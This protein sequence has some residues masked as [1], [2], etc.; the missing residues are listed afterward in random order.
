MNAVVLTSYGPPEALQIRD[1]APPLPKPGQ[2]RIQ[3]RATTVTAGDAELRRS[4]LPWLFRLPLRLWMGW[5]RPRASHA[6]LGMEAAGVIDAI[7]EGV[8][9][10]A[11]G[12]AVF[13]MTDL[14]FG[15]YAEQV[16]V[17]A[18]GVIAHKPT[19][20]SFEQVAP[21]PTG[22][23][24]ALG[25][26]RLGGIAPGKRVL[27]RGALGSIG[28]YAVQLARHHFGAEVTALCGPEDLEEVRELGA[29]TAVDYTVRPF[30]DPEDRY[31]VVLDVVGRTPL[32]HCLGALADGGTYVRATVPGVWELVVSLALRWVSKK[33]I[34]VG[35]A[36]SSAEDLALLGGLV[37]DG[38]IRSVVHRRFAL[39]DAAEAHRYVDSGHKKGNA[40][41]VV[42][43]P[44][45]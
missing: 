3:V 28:S 39:R 15:G 35:D 20:V 19:D 43:P 23:L 13:A 34:V 8:T 11:V 29:T 25:Y 5:S 31:D 26:L 2:V 12:D 40:I 14:G 21:L 9:G 24:A 30:P 4:D 36:G 42:R 18:D 44:D 6:V 22:G 38:T 17:A 32:R 7:G 1:V 16:C 10:F 45:R 41:L 37:A 33:R 27:V